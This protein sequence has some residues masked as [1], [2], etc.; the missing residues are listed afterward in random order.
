MRADLVVGVF[1]AGVIFGLLAGWGMA[2]RQERV[3]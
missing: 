2:V 3:R 1:C